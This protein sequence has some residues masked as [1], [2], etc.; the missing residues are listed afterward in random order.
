M[1]ES[2]LDSLEMARVALAAARSLKAEEP[3]ILD[4]RDVTSITDTFLIVSG[5]SDRQVRSIADQVEAALKGAGERALGI[6]GYR[7]GRWVLMDFVNLVVHVFVPEVRE[8]L[9]PRTTLERCVADR[10]G[11]GKRPVSKPGAR[12]ERAHGRLHTRRVRNR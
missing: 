6:E 10:R 9:Q 7:E 5:R 3:V 11:R 1:P 2:T 8:H 4:L 12:H